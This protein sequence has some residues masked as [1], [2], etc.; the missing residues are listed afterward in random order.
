MFGSVPVISTAA[1]TCRPPAPPP[2]GSYT[3]PVT[4]GGVAR[5][6]P[7]A[8]R[9][10]DMSHLSHALSAMGTPGQGMATPG[11]GMATPGQVMATPGQVMSTPGQVLTTP[12]PAPLGSTSKQLFSSPGYNQTVASVTRSHNTSHGQH[13]EGIGGATGGNRAH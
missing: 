8:G 3:S 13:Q 5:P 2:A 6:G 1:G 4:G 7:G 9:L 12:A 11:Q 10:G